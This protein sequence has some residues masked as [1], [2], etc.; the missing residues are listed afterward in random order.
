M[1][2]NHPPP[3]E[4]RSF[5]QQQNPGVTLV[6]QRNRTRIYSVIF[7][8]A[9]AGL[10]GCAGTSTTMAPI[11]G[12]TAGASFS[13]NV[14]GGQQPVSGSTIQLYAAT[15]GGYGAAATPLLNPAATTNASGGFGIT[16]Q[17]TCPANSM[18][19]ITATGGNPG[20]SAGTNNPN[21]AMM[22]ALGPCSSLSASS[23]IQI[24][25]LTTIGSVWP[26]ARFMS[27]YAALG[28]SPTNTTGMTSAFN[29]V[30]KVVNV[31]SGN[32]PGA[33]L[34]TGAALPTTEINTLA[35]IL[36][37]CINSTGGVATNTSTPCGALF[38]AATPAGGSAPTDTITAA[39]NI[40]RNPGANI[41][42]LYGM[43]TP[44]SPYQPTLSAAPNNFLIG[45]SYV[46]GGLSTPKSLAIDAAGNV[47]TANSGN[48]SLTELSS[49]GTA[50]SP[51]TG[52]TGG[53]L[54]APVSIAFDPSGSLWVANNAGNSVSKFTA[55]GAPVSGTPFTGGGLSTPTSLSVD[56]SGNVWVA[57]SGNNSVTELNSAG[58]ALSPAA[59]YTGAGI[60]TPVGIAVNPK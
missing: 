3:T 10:S 41:A 30:T 39:I 29:A 45:I 14:H 58:A 44:S 56:G 35:D 12:A 33:N 23:F 22:A 32:L 26:L 19:Y 50:L 1:T 20:F 59:G 48:A 9:A 11:V 46:G 60:S 21:L 24:N 57:N 52:F 38:N 53:G 43:A 34:P 28:T 36:A 16:G 7:T 25:E 51:S 18:V 49:A 8:L 17:Y 31:G 55:A 40:A 6:S 15:T 47:W 2:Q 27:G 5:P 37:S 4:S 42:A 13:G 54:N